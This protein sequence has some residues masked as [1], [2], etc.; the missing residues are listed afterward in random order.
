MQVQLPVARFDLPN[1]LEVV[2]APDGRRSHDVAVRLRYH[3]GSTDDPADLPGLA[4]LVEHL[5]FLAS[6]EIPND[7]FIGEL[8]RIGARNVNG[9]TRWDSTEYEAVVDRGALE[10]V[11]W[12]ERQRMISPIDKV[13]ER[14]FA[15]EVRV[16]QD[17]LRLRGRDE[18]TPLVERTAA[19]LVFGEDHPYA[20][21]PGGDSE[22]VARAT[23]ADAAALHRRI[24]GPNNATLVLVG[25]VT[26]ER[27]RAL[28]TRYFGDVPPIA[29]STPREW[30]APR[31]AHKRMAHIEAPIPRPRIAIAWPL[32]PLGTPELAE[33]EAAVRVASDA[34]VRLSARHRLRAQVG[35]LGGFAV[36]VAE[37][38][39]GKSAVDTYDAY[40][41]ALEEQSVTTAQ[42]QGHRASGLAA[43]LFRLEALQSRAELLAS[44]AAVR[45]RPDAIGDE[46]AE[47]SAVEARGVDRIMQTRIRPRD[48]RAVVVVTANPSAPPAGRVVEVR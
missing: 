30:P 1:G 4:H 41:T 29:R 20:R 13:D 24:Y 35:G 17:E 21:S 16:V 40:A 45:G 48:A 3:A 42:V 34:C 9:V 46:L 28:A 15:R 32:P 11:L 14:T 38:L 12:M 26:V 22:S 39:D 18:V 44:Y 43:L 23:R 37:S 6:P 27:A 47:L 25:D 8:E 33:V 5:S 36:V 31:M 7:T 2:V 10:R 19:R